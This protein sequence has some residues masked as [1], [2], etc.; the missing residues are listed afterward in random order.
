MK[1]VADVPPWSTR[2][3]VVV[4]PPLSGAKRSFSC[5]QYTLTFALSVIVLAAATVAPSSG[6]APWNV[7]GTDGP[8]L[9]GS[10]GALAASIVKVVVAPVSPPADAAI[11]IDPAPEAVTV[12]VATPLAAVASRVP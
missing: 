4:G 11:V 9:G 12:F 10:A 1:K 2:S 3:V 6:V 7:G 8:E 5:V